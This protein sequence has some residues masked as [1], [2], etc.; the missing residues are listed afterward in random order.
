MYQPSEEPED[1]PQET[2]EEFQFILRL[3]EHLAEKIN[4]SYQRKC[5]EGEDEILSSSNGSL[6]EQSTAE[7]QEVEY[8][9]EYDGKD[10]DSDMK[11]RKYIFTMEK[12]NTTHF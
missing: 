5:S 12:N 10:Y 3:P 4:Q 8:W 1:E 9:I 6:E 11:D 2:E 7:N